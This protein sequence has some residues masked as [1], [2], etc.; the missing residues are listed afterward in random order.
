MDRFYF[1][2]RQYNSL[3]DVDHYKS[4]ENFKKYSAEAVNMQIKRSLYYM[5]FMSEND[6][7]THLIVR[8]PLLTLA[9][10]HSDIT[11]KADTEDCDCMA[12]PEDLHDCN[13]MFFQY[14]N[15]ARQ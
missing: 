5:R 9:A 12:K 15:A 14:V 4:L 10:I 2:C 1:K 7:V 11:E 3:N 6:P 8:F 13:Y